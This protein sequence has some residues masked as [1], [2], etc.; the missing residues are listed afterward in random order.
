MPAEVC[1]C[2]HDSKRRVATEGRDRNER[3]EIAAKS[4]NGDC[5]TWGVR[6]GC[7]PMFLTS[8]MEALALCRRSPAHGGGNFYRVFCS[9]MGDRGYAIQRRKRTESSY[10]H[11]SQPAEF[12]VK[13]GVATKSLSLNAHFKQPNRE[14]FTGPMYFMEVRGLRKSSD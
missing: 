1:G 12:M 10:V 11:V 4:R 9:G 14:R 2:V 3:P 7:R 6:K 8:P 13:G 5:P